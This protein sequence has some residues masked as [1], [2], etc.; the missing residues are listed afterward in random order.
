MTSKSFFIDLKLLSKHNKMKKLLLITLILQTSFAF[1][2]AAETDA[3]YL[4]TYKTYGY[5]NGVRLDSIDAAY[6]QFGKKMES[7]FFDYGQ[8]GKR[9][10]MVITDKNGLPLIFPRYDYYI[11]K[12]NFFYYNGWDAIPD[13]LINLL[14]KR[15]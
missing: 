12:I 3:V 7:V 11:F 8:D 2:Q 15:N 4:K 14:K 10:D 13:S 6:A 1:S 5:V 9:K